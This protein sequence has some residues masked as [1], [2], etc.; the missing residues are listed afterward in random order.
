MKYAKK[1]RPSVPGGPTIPDSGS[2]HGSGGAEG[3]NNLRQ[4]SGCHTNIMTIATFNARTLSTDDRLHEF[5]EEVKNVKWDVIG[6]SEVRR[7]GENLMTLSNGD[8][9]FHRGHED[10]SYG[11]VGFLISRKICPDIKNVNSVSPRVCYIV[12]RLN[13]R[14]SIKLIQVYAPTSKQGT[15]DDVE[16][17]YEDIETAK[18]E[19]PCHYTI[20][21][22]DFNAK[23]G[24]PLENERSIGQHGL[25]SRNPRGQILVNFLETEHLYAMN[26]FFQ[27]RA[28]RKWTWI[29]PDGRTKNQI[30]Y[31]LSSDKH[32]VTNVDVLSQFKTG[33][34]H[35]L[36]RATLI[37]NL[38]KEREK[39]VRGNLNHKYEKEDYMFLQKEYQTDLKNQFEGLAEA[40]LDV[41]SLNKALCNIIVDTTK[42][43]IGGRKRAEQKLDPSTL[44]LM[45]ERRKMKEHKD[46]QE[47]NKVIHR[48][49]RRDLRKFNT[50]IIT[51]T[52][53][54][55]RGP[56]VFRRKL[57]KNRQQIFKL[58]NKLGIV[59][60]DRDQ[61][62]EIVE[63]FYGELYASQ[64]AEP[65][66]QGDSDPRAKPSE[67]I[68][69]GDLPSIK[70]DEIAHALGQMKRGKASG[71]DGIYVEMLQAGGTPLLE[72]LARLFNIILKTSIT[73]EAWKNAVVTIL[74]KKGDQAK[75]ENY[76]PIS[77]LSQV[78]KL[79][80][81]VICNR[82]SR[83]FDEYQPVEQAGFR[84]G[85]STIDHIHAVKQLMEKCREYN[86]PLCCAFVDYEKAF[87]SIE[88]WAVFQSLHR[89]NIDKR[90]ID[91]LRELYGSATMQVRMHNL[92]S[93]VQIKRGVRQGDTLSPKLFT[94]VLED[95][96][97]TLN[98]D[99]RGVNINGRRLSHLRFADDI[100]ILAEDVSDLQCMLAELH[101]AS[102]K[103]GLRM[104]MSKTK[105]MSSIPTEVSNITVG[106]HKL[107][108][109]NEYT[110]LGHCLSFG[111]ES[112][113]KEITRRIQLGWAAFSKLDDVLKSKIPQCLKTKVFNQ[114]VLP[115]L[116]YGAET[117]TLTKET[118]HR[119]RVAQRAMERAMLG[120][121]L[122]DRIPNVVIRKRTKVFDVGMRVAELKWEWAG[123]LARRE[124]GRWTKAVTEWWPRDGRRAVGRPPARWSDDICKVAGKQ[125][126]RAAQDRKNW[127]TNKEA[128]TQQWAIEG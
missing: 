92:T 39:M 11:G 1:P 55:N 112:Q 66:D 69:E 111:R 115:T 49:I 34:D 95:V 126:I 63:D 56:K 79:Y 106:N 44:S 68:W 2:G 122:R 72:V 25:G 82:L 12:I 89:C 38:E 98:W 4:R 15:E 76:R 103:V 42:K 90:Y 31:I 93:P 9:F 75:L 21:M 109:V 35:R 128:Y 58:K 117:W 121:S 108:V 84:S 22:G 17:F 27:K 123:H 62:L 61:V 45:E 120:I 14:Y 91:T 101:E 114:C 54:Q 13:N 16:L 118:V 113:V 29:S 83:L 71:E 26:T 86:R 47:I 119:I 124:D 40:N 37:Y 28:S 116:T 65:D 23:I 64:S 30:D 74:H 97:K 19:N 20:V 24:P 87:D 60:A 73:P 104:N 78:Y 85:Y 105:V 67:R 81:K 94:N 102:L 48:A 88:H 53:T 59:V 80:A 51:E 10:S 57:N 125:W 50:K 77:L 52:I 46:I 100:I 110:Y 33:S 96:M 99:E 107:E 6:L 32:I 18:R 43:H 36:V 8:M 41:D 5:L 70:E 7:R 3:A 127:R